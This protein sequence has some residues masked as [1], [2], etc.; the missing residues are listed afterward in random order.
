MYYWFPTTEK[1]LKADRNPKYWNLDPPGK[2][3]SFD[4]RFQRFL[5]YMR[6]FYN[7]HGTY[8]V[9][10]TA[11][12][13]SDYPPC[14]GLALLCNDMKDAKTKHEIKNNKTHWTALQIIRFY[15]KHN[16]TNKTKEIIARNYAGRAD[17]DTRCEEPKA[18]IY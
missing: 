2:E 16:H 17:A 3:L 14:P 15:E 13:A 18:Y 9:P 7:K 4:E 1:V 8:N 6:L 11:S 10:Q 12:G 5:D